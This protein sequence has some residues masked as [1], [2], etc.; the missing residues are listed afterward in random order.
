MYYNSGMAMLQYFHVA[1][2]SGLSTSTAIGIVEE[3][4][5]HIRHSRRRL[6]YLLWVRGPEGVA[7][8][9]DA[10]FHPS[11][12]IV[13]SGNAGLVEHAVAQHPNVCRAETDARYP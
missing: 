1:Y 8:V 9:E 13:P 2:S 11:F 7:C 4:H 3:P 12:A 6:V 5:A 10:E